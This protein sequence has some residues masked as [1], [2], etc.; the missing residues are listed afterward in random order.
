MWKSYFLTAVRNIRNNKLSSLVAMLGFGIGLLADL[1]HVFKILP[2][3][4]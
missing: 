3:N 1:Y 2:G 4:L